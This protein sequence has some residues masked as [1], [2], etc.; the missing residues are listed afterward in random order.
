M[1]IFTV[2]MS[3]ILM[4]TVSGCG[5]ER[6]EKNGYTFTDSLGREI[7][8]ES[9]DSVAAL[10][11]SFADIWMLSGGEVCA[12]VDDAWSDLNL[13]LPDTCVNLGEI[14]KMSFEKLLSAKPDFVIASS[15]IKQHTEFKDSLE[16][17]GICVAY[18]DVSSFQDYL[19]MLKICTDINNRPDLYEKNGE[20]LKSDID[21]TIEKSRERVKENGEQKVLF[22]RASASFIRAKGNKDT[23]LG[24]ML[25]D[26][27]CINIADSDTALLDNLSVESILKENP[28]RIFIV[29]S[30]DDPD[31]MKKAVDNMFSE[32]P[33]WEQLD[34]VKNDRVY[35]LE[36]QLYNFKPNS[37]WSEAYEKL[38]KILS[39]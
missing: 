32:N 8:V 11:G 18:F 19:D 1:R 17:M 10:S 35:F 38:E 25:S 24:E 29:L 21:K 4:L 30:G 34:A 9:T 13:Q 15:A 22:L 27:G 7:T 26:L 5:N 20:A 39:E 3:F 6:I 14:N 2:L 28:Y 23:V 16:S 31:G 37:R 12:T 33:M 36:K